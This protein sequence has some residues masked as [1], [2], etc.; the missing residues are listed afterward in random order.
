MIT[1]SY[2]HWDAEGAWAVPREE[3]WT[4]ELPL[5][6]CRVA[7]AERSVD[8]L[9]FPAAIVTLTDED[10]ARFGDLTTRSI[11]RR[12]AVLVDGQVVLTPTVAEPLAARFEL[13][14]RFSE[15]DVG[16]LLEHLQPPSG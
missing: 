4:L 15:K 1:A 9:G 5:L 3:I 12:L 7:Q 11:G 8:G 2:P 10:A 13:S 6:T 16:R 14:G